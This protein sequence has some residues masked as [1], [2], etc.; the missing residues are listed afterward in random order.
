M[1]HLLSKKYC[2]PATMKTYRSI[3]H[4]ITCGAS[5][6]PHWFSLVLIILLTL[7]DIEQVRNEPEMVD[8]TIYIYVHVYAHCTRCVVACNNGH[9]HVHCMC[10]PFGNPSATDD[11]QHH[12]GAHYGHGRA[13]SHQSTP[14]ARVHRS[15]S[16][17]ILLRSSSQTRGSL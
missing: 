6:S 2:P 5:I 1:Q 3:I 15:R 9:V 10:S 7:T 16:D 4:L 11:L 8:L 14:H 17:M 12:C 13:H